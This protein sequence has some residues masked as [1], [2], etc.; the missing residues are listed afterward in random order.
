MYDI[1]KP[2]NRDTI[3]NILKNNYIISITLIEPIKKWVKDWERMKM[4]EGGPLP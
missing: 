2:V 1:H 4:V 3:E